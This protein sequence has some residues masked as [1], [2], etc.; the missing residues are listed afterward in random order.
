MNVFG[1]HVTRLSALLAALDGALFLA[2]LHVLAGV[3]PCHA[4][5]FGTVVHL[6]MY[7]AVLLTVAFL[8]ITASVGLYNTATSQNIRTFLKR[9]VLAW[10]LLFVPSVVFIG[11]S[12]AAVG[13]PFGWFIGVTSLAISLFMF[14]LLLLHVAMGWCFG[15]PFMKKRVLV[16]GDGRCAEAVAHYVNGPGASRFCHVETV[17]SW[18]AVHGPPVRMGNLALKAPREEPASLTSMA[19]MLRADEIVVAIDDKTRLPVS[20]LLDCKLSGVEVVDAVTFWEREA[21]R[22]DPSDVGPSWLTFSGG[23]T[24]DQRRRIIKRALDWTVSLALLIVALPIGA[25]TAL[26]I[27]LESPGPVF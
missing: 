10:Q 5:Y 22:I 3:D 24:C 16:F 18:R 14:V 4:C 9:F 19:L 27:K 11:L 2:V 21:G 12:K 17:S 1:H 15:L 25:I 20:E 7:Q 8:L 6:R 26:L 23:F 13:A